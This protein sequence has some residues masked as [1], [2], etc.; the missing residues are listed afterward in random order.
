MFIP[1]SIFFAYCAGQFWFAYRV[2]TVLV[3]RHPEEW[4][5]M[6]KRFSFSIVPWRF[7]WCGRHREL[8]DAVL[9]RRVVEMRCL[10]IVAYTSWAAFVIG[11]FR[12][13]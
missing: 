12:P 13:Y 2:R 10:T 1:F 5:K 7:V 8:G 9:S 11:V 4:L 3:T 6:S